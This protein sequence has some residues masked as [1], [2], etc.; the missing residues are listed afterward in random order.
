MKLTSILAAGAVLALTSCQALQDEPWARVRKGTKTVGL[1]TGWAIYSA[2]VEAEG[3]NGVLA[4]AGIPETGTDD[5]DLTA[6]Y[7][8]AL[9]TNYYLTD[10][11]SIGGIVEFRSFDADPVSPLTAELEPDTFETLHFLLSARYWPDPIG[12]TRRWRPF[13]GLDLGY[14]PNVEFDNVQVTYE[15]S[16]GL[17]PETVQLEGEAYWTLAPVVGMS[18]LLRDNLSLELGGFYEFA[19]TPSEETLT[20]A[21]LGGAQA[22]VEVWPEG[23]IFFAGLTYYF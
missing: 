11:F 2:E 4:P 6:R 14:I 15:A 8:G 3:K 19:F 1:S 13:V 7:G 5:T 17:P 20:L 23:F 9:K 21:N 12:E 16:S 22:D 18:Y 10:R